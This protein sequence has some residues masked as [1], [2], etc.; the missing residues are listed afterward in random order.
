MPDALR[1]GHFA[2]MDQPFDALFE[3]HE[4]SVAHHVDDCASDLCTNGVFIL[5]FFPRAGRF[6]LQAEGDFFFL[7]VD[8]QYLHFDFLVDGNHL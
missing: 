2:D 7:V 5:D 8:V 1:P 3:F 6:L 4:R